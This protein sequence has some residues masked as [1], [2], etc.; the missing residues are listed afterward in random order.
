MIQLVLK[1]EID[2]EH[3]KLS[4]ASFILSSI[5]VATNYV[6]YVMA[7]YIIKQSYKIN[8]RNIIDF[9]G[10]YILALITIALL[11]ISVI[12]GIIDLKKDN[13]RKKK[14]THFFTIISFI[15]SVLVAITA[16]L[17]FILSI[18]YEYY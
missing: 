9:P 4:I 16:I 10:Y 18:T 2:V 11:A 12:I 1:K 15:I 6:S 8:N 17:I 14:Y 5:S 3:N 13:K 7:E